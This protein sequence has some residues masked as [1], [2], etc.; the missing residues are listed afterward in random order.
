MLATKTKKKEDTQATAVQSPSDTLQNVTLPRDTLKDPMEGPRLQRSGSAPTLTPR[1]PKEVP[2]PSSKNE[3]VAPPPA[4]PEPSLRVRSN[5]IGGKGRE[6]WRKEQGTKLPPVE[7][8]PLASMQQSTK[9]VEGGSSPKVYVDRKAKEDWVVKRGR[10]YGQV[11][12]ANKTENQA[13][14]EEVYGAELYGKLVG[15]RTAARGQVFSDSENQ[16]YVGSKMLTGFQDWKHLQGGSNKNAPPTPPTDSKDF[17]KHTGLGPS[18]AAARFLGDTDTNLENVGAVSKP[19]NENE[20]PSEREYVKIDFGH[21]FRFGNDEKDMKA[22]LS[23]ETLGGGY[24]PELMSQLELDES[25]EHIAKLSWI[26][27]LNLADRYEPLIKDL[28]LK[29]RA[30][31]IY[32]RLVTRQI[33]LRKLLEDR[34]KGKGSAADKSGKDEKD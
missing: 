1:P 25:L 4:P 20:A 31:G 32:R 5:S 33:E 23:P 19:S 9:T 11:L 6:A 14:V 8:A 12:D 2:A 24:P 26:E 15:N 10:P 16:L 34:K 17:E 18:L 28:N 27:L 29:S 30:P 7:K 22:M 13:V 21:A 3:L